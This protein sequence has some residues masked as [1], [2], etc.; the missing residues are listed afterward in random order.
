MSVKYPAKGYIYEYLAIKIPDSFGHGLLPS[1]S[2][3]ASGCERGVHE[4][5]KQKDHYIY[6]QLNPITNSFFCDCNDPNV[7]RLVI[8]FLLFSSSSRVK[9][10]TYLAR[11]ERMR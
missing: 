11:D 4:A 2:S 3:N 8:I 6:F 10:N 9:G 7:Q 5:I 1:A